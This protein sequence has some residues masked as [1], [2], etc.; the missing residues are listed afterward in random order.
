MEVYSLSN[1]IIKAAHYYK[2]IKD[3][4]ILETKNFNKYRTEKLEFN[5][6]NFKEY[7]P[8]ILEYSPITLWYFLSKKYN[9]L[10]LIKSENLTIKQ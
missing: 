7:K 9:N 10:L 5:V 2:V 8:N 4:A 1:W 6:L 3:L